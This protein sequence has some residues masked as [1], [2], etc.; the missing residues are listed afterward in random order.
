MFM[1]GLSFREK[2]LPIK[3]IADLYW[4]FLTWSDMCCTFPSL[5]PH[6]FT[7]ALWS[8]DCRYKETVKRRFLPRTIRWR[9]QGSDLTRSAGPKVQGCH[10]CLL[11]ICPSFILPPNGECLEGCLISPLVQPFQ[12]FLSCFLSHLRD[13]EGPWVP[14]VPWWWL[15]EPRPPTIYDSDNRVDHYSFLYFIYWK[16]TDTLKMFCKVSECHFRTP[17]KSIMNHLFRCININIFNIF[18]HLD[19]MAKIRKAYCFLYKAVSLFRLLFF[20]LVHF[21]DHWKIVNQ[22]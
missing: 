4:L 11:G 14:V 2:K 3:L 7:A 21:F 20:W 18:W 10:T 15:Y 16:N 1:W 5:S 17:V 9:G 19:I 12:I 8:R 13:A 6:V 22:G